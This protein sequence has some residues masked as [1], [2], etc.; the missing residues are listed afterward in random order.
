VRQTA[1]AALAA[2]CIAASSAAQQQAMPDDPRA[3][4]ALNLFGAACMAALGDPDRTSAWAGLEDLPAIDKEELATLLHGKKGHAWNASG[5]NG[6]A[7]LVLRE[8]GTCSVWARRAPAAQVNGWFTSM[9]EQ[10][11]RD[12]S[13]AVKVEDREIDGR[14]GRYR[15]LAYRL[16]SSASERQFLLSSTST[17]AEGDDV[18]AQV[19]LSVAEIAPK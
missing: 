10:A 2:G 5:P 9:A 18:I 4:Y 1:L 14:G 16:S 12:G 19:I 15:L 8:E 13:H 11:T 3:V 7:L 17:E 6:D